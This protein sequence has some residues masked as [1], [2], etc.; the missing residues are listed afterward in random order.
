MRYVTQPLGLPLWFAWKTEN[1]E[2]KDAIIIMLIRKRSRTAVKILQLYVQSTMAGTERTQ[3][4]ALN[5]Y[6]AEA[7]WEIFVQLLHQRNQ[8]LIGMRSPISSQELAF[9]EN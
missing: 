1:M 7:K 4:N 5:Q 3:E 2:R 9:V 6:T 8:A